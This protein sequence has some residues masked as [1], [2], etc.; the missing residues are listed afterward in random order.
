MEETEDATLVAAM[1]RLGHDL[2]IRVVACRASPVADRARRPRSSRRAFAAPLRW[3]DPP[4]GNVR[5][6][7]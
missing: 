2:G 5:G 7:M 1:I 6:E 4:G 3:E